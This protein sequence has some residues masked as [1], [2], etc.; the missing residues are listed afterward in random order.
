MS[1]KKILVIN[2]GSSSLKYQLSIMPEGIDLVKG[3][4]ERI[5]D[6]K[7]FMTHKRVADG[8]KFKVEATELKFGL[9]D[10]R[11]SFKEVIKAILDSDHGVLSNVNEI[12]V[13]AH[14]I[15]QGGDRYSD[16]AVVNEKVLSDIEE[17]CDLAPLHNPAH[18]QGI[19][20]ATEILPETPQTVTFD[21]AFHQTMPA[22]CYM[23]AIP[24]EL[25]TKY[26]LRKYGAHGTSHKYVTGRTAE[27]EGKKPE[28]CNMVIC[29]LGNGASITAIKNG[30]SYDTSMGLTPLEG[31]AM[32][33]RSGDIDP[34]IYYY[35]FQK[36]FS[37]EEI[38]NIL[39]KKSGLLGLSGKTND[40]RDV[41]DSAEKE[42]EKG[43]LAMSV[44]VNRVK[45]YIGGYFA[46]LGH[47]DYL[48]FTGGIGEN[49]FK[50]RRRVC[51]NLENLGIKID[52]TENDK[53]VG[54]EGVISTADSKV[55]VLVVPTNEE[56]QIALDAYRITK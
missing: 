43:L 19:K 21:T 56:Y 22:A 54:E 36:G 17:L 11:S 48:V 4:V 9:S 45:K 2:C 12:D 1:S 28:D 7:A 20:A 50:I 27:I 32:G 39:Q 44:W 10:H 51:E 33:T 29:H 49:S 55:K 40:M 46:E 47:V 30:L 53:Y 34:T 13:I 31:L 16:A 15:V 24:Y 5:G 26:K 38:N 35:L 14:R 25:Y 18:L 52:Q 8:K 37:V 3:V 41:I 6:D 42:E 23:Y